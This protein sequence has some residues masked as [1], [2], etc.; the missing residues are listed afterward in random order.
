MKATFVTDDLTKF[1]TSCD[2]GD[3]PDPKLEPIKSYVAEK[4][5]Y[6]Q[7]MLATYGRVP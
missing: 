3:D 6:M 2:D 1:S 4:Y 7:P 5:E